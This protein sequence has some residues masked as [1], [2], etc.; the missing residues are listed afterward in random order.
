MVR[1]K[2]KWEVGDKKGYLSKDTSKTAVAVLLREELRKYVL[3]HSEWVM[4][5]INEC[6]RRKVSDCE[7][8]MHHKQRLISS[9]DYL[10][11]RWFKGL[12]GYFTRLFN[13]E[14]A[15]G[16]YLDLTE[17]P[18]CLK[19]SLPHT[20][21]PVAMQ[22]SY[23]EAT[24]RTPLTYLTVWPTSLASC[25]RQN[26][27]QVVPQS[28]FSQSEMDGSLTQLPPQLLRSYDMYRSVEFLRL[29]QDVLSLTPSTQC[30]MYW[31]GVPSSFAVSPTIMLSQAYEG[32]VTPLNGKNGFRSVS[33]N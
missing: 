9:L 30:A 26:V 7:H 15:W 24:S 19:D 17:I 11:P 28:C 21:C 23:L 29:V 6:W 4:H 33:G 10:R 1:G 20:L 5:M 27:A 25:S 12:L 14:Q 2:G 18:S 3:N 31:D 16:S 32:F 8:F 22:Q 13:K